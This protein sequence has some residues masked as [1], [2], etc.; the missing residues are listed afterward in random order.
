MILERVSR[1]QKISPETLWEDTFDHLVKYVRRRLA[2]QPNNRDDGEDIAASVFKSLIRGSSER[3]FEALDDLQEL[4]KLLEAM[5]RRK[6]VDR[7]RYQSQKKRSADRVPLDN[8]SNLSVRDFANRK[9]T[10]NTADQGVITR[11]LLDQ[12][13]QLLPPPLKDLVPLRLQGFEHNEIAQILEVSPSTVARKL[14]LIRETWKQHL[15]YQI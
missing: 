4:V 11:E 1:K 10:V 9:E 2:N 8:V 3:R 15:D 7:I 6:I 12:A 13:C 14:A 5:A